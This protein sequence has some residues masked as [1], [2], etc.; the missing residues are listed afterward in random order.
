MSSSYKRKKDHHAFLAQCLGK[1]DHIQM[2]NYDGIANWCVA[3]F[4]QSA[5]I[6]NGEGLIGNITLANDDEAVIIQPTWNGELDNYDIAFQCINP[7]TD[8]V[9]LNIQVSNDN[10]A[11]WQTDANYHYDQIYYD[12]G[13]G[14]RTAASSSTS[15][16]IPFVPSTATRGIG[17]AAD[18]SISGWLRTGQLSSTSFYKI[19]NWQFMWNTAAGDSGVSHGAG[20][21][22]GNT[23]AITGIKVV[24]SSGQLKNG[25]LKVKGK[26]K[27]L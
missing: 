12:N 18:E 26:K 17:N 27:T 5:S 19:F 25:Q 13:L 22:K 14:T 6:I 1:T 11:T 8:D 15:T 3:H 9:Q 20:F 24:M 7:Q 4:G 23:D 16:A 21:Y 10:G 2:S